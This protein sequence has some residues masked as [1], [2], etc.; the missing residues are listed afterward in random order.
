MIEQLGESVG[1]RGTTSV[2]TFYTRECG[3]DGQIWWLKVPDGESLSSILDQGPL[4]IKVALELVAYI[5]DVL[6]V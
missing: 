6:S 2:S 4:A 1:S 3:P 5:A